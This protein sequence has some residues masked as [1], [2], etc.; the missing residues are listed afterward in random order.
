MNVEDLRVVVA[1]DFGTT[2]SGFAYSHMKNPNVKVHSSFPGHFS[3]KTNT[4]LQYDNKWKVDCWGY[5]ALARE[6]SKKKKSRVTD[7]RPVELFK[8]HLA[9]IDHFK[10]PKLPT[11]IDYKTAIADFLKEME[12][13]NNHSLLLILIKETLFSRWS[14]LTYSQIRFVFS[15]P[16]E[17]G[18]QTRGIMRECIY[19]AGYL[20]TKNSYNLEFI[21]EPEA[22]AIFCM[23]IMKE[24]GLTVGGKF[25]N[26]MILITWIYLTKRL[27]I[28]LDSFMVC[29]CGGGTV[30]LTTRTLLPNNQLGEITERTGDLCGSTFVDEEFF[31]FLSRRLGF[32]AMQEFREKHYGQ[33]QYLILKFFCP[34]IKFQFRNDALKFQPIELDIERECPALIDYIDE[35]IQ[36]QMREEEWIIEFQYNDVKSMFDPVVERIIRLIRNQLNASQQQKCSAIFVVGGFAESG[37]LI[38][39]IRKA[40]SSEIRT[41]AVPQQ[42][43]TAVVI[44]AVRYGLN[45]KVIKTRKVPLTYGVEVCPIWKDGDEKKR[46]T[47]AGRI[48]KFAELAKRGTESPPDQMFSDDFVPIYE[49]QKRITFKIF[50]TEKFEAQFCDEPGVNQVGIL[51][52]KLGNEELGLRRPVEFGLTFAEEEIR[53]TAWNKVTGEIFE[54]SFD[55]LVASADTNADVVGCKSPIYCP[56]ELLATIQLAHLFNDSKTFV[57]MPTKKPIHE[58]LQAFSE[59]PSPHTQTSL[60]DF[61][62]TYF[63]SPDLSLI[64]TTFPNFNPSPIFLEKIQDNTLR[65]FASI[66]NN[67]WP[68]LSRRVVK[69]SSLCKGCASSMIPVKHTFIV[70]GGRFREFYYWDSYFILEG[71]LVSGYFHIAREIIENFLQMIEEFANG[72]RIYY[73]NRSMPPLL[74]QMVKIYYKATNDFDLVKFALPNLLKEYE[75]WQKNTTVHIATKNYSSKKQHVLNRYIVHNSDPRPESFLED[76]TTATNAIWLNASGKANLYADIATAAESGWDFSSRWIRA[77]KLSEHLQDT[78]TSEPNNY[79]LL[80]NLNTRSVVPV[81][82]NSILYMNEIALADFNV[83]VGNLKLAKSFRKRAKERREGIVDIFWDKN[84]SSFWDYNLTSGVH[85]S[86]ASLA[87]FFP[88]WAGIYPTEITNNLTAAKESFKLIKNFLE[89]YPGSLPATEINTGLQWDFPNAWPPLQYVI[90]TS[91][92]STTRKNSMEDAGHIFEKYNATNLMMPGGGGEYVVQTGFGWTNGVMLW[93]LEKFGGVLQEPECYHNAM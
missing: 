30:D 29:D 23:Q 42:P 39:R 5:A 22:A 32:N 14:E 38:S 70:P 20:E 89:K 18:P 13:A 58:I 84:R 27:I 69:D 1:V 41:I 37:Y 73:L 65:A 54:A 53:A 86:V 52:I 76:Y 45:K 16:A 85:T 67:Y 33:Y 12:K 48:L 15:V 77:E 61:I 55:G 28:L 80:Q 56:S 21:S 78:S 62:D 74:T 68:D 92:F 93:I 35:D 63:S 71:L 11:E 81:E 50:S 47:H 3:P 83:A 87:A 26:H 40:F 49:D 34:Q 19:H 24:H 46:K 82:L 36:E 90:H 59:L 75:F 43:I 31:L 66:I 72:N 79:A 25:Q 91:N 51:T 9:D 10:K 60:R 44:G 64:S 8:L 6:P 57:D 17:W 4:V 88:F 2:Y 7:S